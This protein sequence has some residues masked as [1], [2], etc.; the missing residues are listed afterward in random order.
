MSFRH[1]V[2]FRSA[3]FAVATLTVSAAVADTRLPSL[4]SL[5]PDRPLWEPGG[6]YL[7]GD[8]GTGL[9]QRNAGRA[10]PPAWFFDGGAQ[11]PDVAI[12]RSRIGAGWAAS[13]GVGYRVGP[14]L[15]VELSGVALSGVGVRGVGVGADF[16]ADGGAFGG[17][18]ARSRASAAVA[19]VYWDILT[20]RGLTP[21]VGVGAGV[22]WSRLGDVSRAATPEPF[23][24]ATQIVALRRGVRARPALALHAGV[25]YELAPGAFLDASY[26]YLSL[27]SA[28]A[29]RL[30]CDLA[31][32][33]CAAATPARF[34]RLQAHALALGLRWEL[35]GP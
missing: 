19:S 7:R 18:R 5:E 25:A 23:A 1:A 28:A 33:E 11:T 27:G 17:W 21:Y 20:W 2:F 22:A 34:R 13:A 6:V 32:G 15:R 30:A 12:A 3:V 9:G 31:A 10:V 24:P 29:G 14:S 8:L 26:R 35:G 16:P 4:P